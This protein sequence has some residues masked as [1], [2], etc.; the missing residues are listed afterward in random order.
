MVN[1]VNPSQMGQPVN[2][3]VKPGQRQSTVVNRVRP[4]QHEPKPDM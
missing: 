2:M 4:G 3:A 1:S